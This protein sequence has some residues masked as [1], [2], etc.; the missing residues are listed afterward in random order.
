MASLGL[1]DELEKHGAGQKI[2][3]E[4]TKNA[5]VMIDPALSPPDRPLAPEHLPGQAHG[6]VSVKPM[7]CAVRLLPSASNFSASPQTSLTMLV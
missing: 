1:S 4:Q 6:D 7:V 2:H 5:I 3:E